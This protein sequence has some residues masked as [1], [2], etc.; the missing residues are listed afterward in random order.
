M[1]EKKTMIGISVGTRERLKKFGRKGESY[2]NVI[3]RLLKK[4]GTNE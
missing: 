1:K 3:K 2:D 4:V